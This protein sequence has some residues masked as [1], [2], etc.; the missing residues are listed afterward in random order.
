V[1]IKELGESVKQKYKEYVQFP[2]EE[3]GRRIIEKYPIY[4]NSVSDEEMVGLL[5]K[6]ADLAV[7][8]RDLQKQLEVETD[9][10]RNQRMAVEQGFV[11][12]NPKTLTNIYRKE[13]PVPFTSSKILGRYTESKPQEEL[14]F[15]DYVSMA[16]E[17][18]VARGFHP[19]PVISQMA[20]ESERGTSRFARERNNLFGI[21]A[22]D[23]NLNNTWRFD[24][25]GD[26]IDA[27]LDLIEKDP[28]YKK[29]Y[30]NRADPEAYIKALAPVYASDKKYAWKIMNTPE[31]RSA[32]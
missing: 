7:K 6:R 3:L 32:M 2:V 28:R 19:A 12:A 14:S 24:N 8:K 20:S 4:K 25:P 21:G 26:S 29:A 27:Y 5:D 23:Y 15:K 10:A 22:F 9:P 17:K 30:E 31:W 16:T 1:T 11:P 18:A 13:E